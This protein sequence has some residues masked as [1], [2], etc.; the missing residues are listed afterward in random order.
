M[1]PKTEKKKLESNAKLNIFNLTCWFSECRECGWCRGRPARPRSPTAAAR[2]SWWTQPGNMMLNSHRWSVL[3]YL[4]QP[5]YLGLLNIGGGSV[6]HRGHLQP[7]LLLLEIG[8]VSDCLIWSPIATG[9]LLTRSPWSQN[10]F[11]SLSTHS[12]YSTSGL[13][14]L[15]RSEQCTMFCRT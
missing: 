4:L 8:V 13:V 10:S 15:E 14:G 3:L 1:G 11:M 5:I 2:W 9:C 12:L 6:T 7:L